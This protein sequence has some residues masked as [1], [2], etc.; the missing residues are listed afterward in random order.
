MV[1]CFR[2]QTSLALARFRVTTP[3]RGRA[4]I[5]TCDSPG[6]TLAAK[7]RARRSL[8]AATPLP[9]TNLLASHAPFARHAHFAFTGKS[10]ADMAISCPTRLIARAP[11]KP[12]SA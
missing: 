2:R 12:V 6:A 3:A 7:T 11:P 4:R 1:T 10:A 8:A 9:L 5:L